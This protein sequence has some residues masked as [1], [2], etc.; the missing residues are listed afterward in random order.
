M[1]YKKKVTKIYS[2]Y[3][4][5]IK[6]THISQTCNHEVTGSNSYGTSRVI[7]IE[8][9]RGCGLERDLRYGSGKY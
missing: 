9:S 3:F 6:I 1:Y 8:V 2:L 4:V 7:Q 5:S